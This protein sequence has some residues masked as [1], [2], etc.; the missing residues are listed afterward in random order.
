MRSPG[1]KVGKAPPAPLIELCECRRGKLHVSWHQ[2]GET[3]T[4][5]VVEWRQD[6]QWFAKSARVDASLCELPL[7]CAAP[8]V[9]RVH[10]LNGRSAGP[11]SASRVAAEAPTP[12]AC[13][14]EVVRWVEEDP[15]SPVLV[16]LRVRVTCPRA[17]DAAAAEHG[18]S[19]L[20]V[21][22]SATSIS[23]A[24]GV[25]GAT[26]GARADGRS[27]SAVVAAA[28]PSARVRIAVEGAD[29][30][31]ARVRIVAASSPNGAAAAAA[32]IN[33]AVTRGV[34]GA[35]R[36]V[37]HGVAGGYAIS[38]DA[39]AGVG[40][41]VGR[42]VGELASVAAAWSV[43]TTLAVG[44]ALSQ[45]GRRDVLPE[46]VGHRPPPRPPP[47]H[48]NARE[49]HGCAAAG[50][51]DAR[52]GFARRRDHCRHCGRSFC[53]QHLRWRHRLDHK[54][55]KCG[56]AP[57]RVCE[58]RACSAPQEPPPARARRRHRS[59]MSR[60]RACLTAHCSRVV[61]LRAASQARRL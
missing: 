37:G 6:R 11:W 8:V 30:A 44:E 13:A 41:T 10:A 48:E 12:T 2:H 35:L 50:A 52:F 43:D 46:K 24:A 59:M 20:S 55:D 4:A 40:V 27:T 3:A 53:Q 1:K 36:S 42:G 18:P 54:I 39:I 47:P 26:A 5:W 21:Q 17:P 49:C 22:E 9:V 31:A 28:Q 14:L 61:G 7:S 23:G 25:A 60:V 51:A 34:G 16:L 33:V 57:L 19:S 38:S 45:G 58:V 56:A 29:T 32:R 15:L